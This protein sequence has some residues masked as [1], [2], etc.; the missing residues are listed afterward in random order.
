[1]TYLAGDPTTQLE[2]ESLQKVT[3]RPGVKVQVVLTYV[4]NLH[5]VITL[6]KMLP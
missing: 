3:Q 1:M 5:A 2:K 6:L 4:D